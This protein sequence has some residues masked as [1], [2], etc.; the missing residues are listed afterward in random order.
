VG[1]AG[2]LSWWAQLVGSGVVGLAGWLGEVGSAGGG[3]LS[4]GA[5]CSLWAER[6]MGQKPGP[7]GAARGG[8]LSSRAAA[9]E[10]LCAGG[11]GMQLLLLLL[12][13]LPLPLPLLP[14]LPHLPR[15]ICPAALPPPLLYTPSCPSHSLPGK[16]SEA[17]VSGWWMQHHQTPPCTSVWCCHP[18]PPPQRTCYCRGACSSCLGRSDGGWK[19]LKCAPKPWLWQRA[20]AGGWLSGEVRRW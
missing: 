2:G 11:R 10:H 7:A 19:P 3:G 15:P 16:Q 13:L 6:S 4:I 9:S 14:P 17:G 8:G 20:W 18:A 12:L 1:S 5:R